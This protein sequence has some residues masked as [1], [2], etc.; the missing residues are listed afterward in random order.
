M[1]K[2]MI[3]AEVSDGQLKPYSKELAVK[4]VELANE[5]NG[6][7]VALAFGADNEEAVAQLG[8]YG[9]ASCTLAEH[10]QLQQYLGEAFTHAAAA[11]IDTI[12]PQIILASASDVGKDLMPRLAM[13]LK[14]GL[15]SDCIEL[16]I[17]ANQLKARRPIFAGKA[18]VDVVFNSDVQ[19]A[20]ARPNSFAWQEADNDT[21]AVVNKLSV[22]V[23]ELSVTVKEVKKAESGMVSLTEADIVVSGGRAMGSAENFSII[24]DLADSLGAAVGASRAA[25]D[26]GYISHDHQVGQT[27]KTVNTL[28]AMR[29]AF[30]TSPNIFS[31]GTLALF[32]IKGTVEEP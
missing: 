12:Q 24:Q 2:I 32:K 8:A 5:C 4:A 29:C 26:A 13:R 23:P 19:L 7:V 1:S 3:I 9:V 31:T 14:A 22:N 11:A 20:T 16:S 10:D 21:K 25:V 30:P 17:D 28:K 18:M 6:E 27:G 15:A